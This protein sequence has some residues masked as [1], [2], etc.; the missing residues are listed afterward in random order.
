MS[1]LHDIRTSSTYTTHEQYAAD[2][3]GDDISSVELI[4]VSGSDLDVVNAARVSFGKMKTQLTPRDHK[5]IRFLMMHDHTSPFEH[6]QLSFRVKAPMFVARQWM[7]HRI[8][9][10]NEISYRY[11]KAP[12][13]FYTPLYWR[14]QDT[15]N[16][17]GSYGQFQ[18]DEATRMY[19]DAINASIYAYEQLI[20]KG[21]ARE[22]ARAILPVCAY[23]QYIYTC[24]LLSFLHFI[25][26]RIRSDAQ[27][28]IRQYAHA[29]LHM[30]YE[31][32]PVSIGTFLEK[33]GLYGTVGIEHS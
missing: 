6:N 21:I 27:Y 13:E 22:Q 23:T 20:E 32:F 2:P 33:H 8:N 1:Q 26:L 12:L 17:Q 25:N 11:V 14:Y 31:F 30:A 5:L 15:N 19:H 7:R 28:E 16:K 9:S 29:M 3:L 4:R 10:Y 18:D 24:N